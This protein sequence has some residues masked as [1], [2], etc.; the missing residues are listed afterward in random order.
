MNFVFR[1]YFVEYNT[2]WRLCYAHKLIQFEVRERERE[3]HE[4]W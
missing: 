2:T 4:I 3:R 1:E